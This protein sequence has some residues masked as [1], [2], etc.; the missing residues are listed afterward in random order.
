VPEEDQ[1]ELAASAAARG[2]NRA[3][4]RQASPDEIELLLRAVY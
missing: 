2:G 3:N 1:P 4:P